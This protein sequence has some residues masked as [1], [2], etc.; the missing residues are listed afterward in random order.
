MECSLQQKGEINVDQAHRGYN[1]SDDCSG[2]R[3]VNPLFMKYTPSDG[4]FSGQQGYGYRYAMKLNL[5]SLIL[6]FYSRS[7]E[8][9]IEAVRAINAGEK[10]VSSFDH[11][12]VASLVSTY[13]T[14]AIL[15]AGRRSLNEGATI[16]ICYDDPNP[17]MPTS[18]ETLR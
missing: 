14:T 12:I 1:M 13:R 18:L 3:S 7:F 8:V 9:F 2:F 6:I 4:K 10:T 16:K 15:E 5:F 17:C 11:S